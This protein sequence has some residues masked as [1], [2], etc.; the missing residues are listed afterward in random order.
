MR[1]DLSSEISS[2]SAVSAFIVMLLAVHRTVAGRLEWY[3]RGST[4]VRASRRIHLP[5]KSSVL[6]LVFHCAEKFE[7]TS[8]LN[9]PLSYEGTRAT[10]PRLKYACILCFS[11]LLV[12]P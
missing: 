8:I 9:A 5:L 10:I 2:R 1:G 4:A 11:G 6:V 7:T 12:N 3:L